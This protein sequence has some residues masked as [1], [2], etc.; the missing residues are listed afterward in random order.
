MT[1]EL[2]RLIDATWTAKLEA[3]AL[4]RGAL[5]LQVDLKKVNAKQAGI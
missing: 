2:V 1:Q 4:A 5:R 3:V